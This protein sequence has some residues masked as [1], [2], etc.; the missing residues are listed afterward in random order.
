M[1]V[2][3]TVKCLLQKIPMLVL[4]IAHL[5]LPILVLII[6]HSMSV[7]GLDQKKKCLYA[8]AKLPSVK[9]SFAYNYIIINHNSNKIKIKL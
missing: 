8:Q 4:F 2:L 5:F 3:T 6:G 9:S 1:G 7:E